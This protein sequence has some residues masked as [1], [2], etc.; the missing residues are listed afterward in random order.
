MSTAPQAFAGRFAT[1]AAIGLLAVAGASSGQQIVTG[2]AI[3]SYQTFGTDDLSSRG[4]RQIYDLDYQRN[5][6]EPLRLRLSFRGDGSDGNQEF[7]TFQTKNSVWQLRPLGE[8]SYFLP[9]VNFLARYELL[10]TKASFDALEFRR[11]TE[12]IYSTLGW[13]PE[14]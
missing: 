13:S 7:S 4:F 8:L 1:L 14:E 11:K 6:L 5:V 9:T 10:D 2:R 12:R 3:F